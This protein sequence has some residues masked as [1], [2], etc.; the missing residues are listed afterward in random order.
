MIVG[1]TDPGVVLKRHRERIMK[2]DCAT[3]AATELYDRVQSDQE[4]ETADLLRRGVLRRATPGEV[5]R[6][7]TNMRV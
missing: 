7:R 4:Q 1:D 5:T 2:R 6:I 3:V